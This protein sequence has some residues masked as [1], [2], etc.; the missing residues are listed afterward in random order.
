MS[1]QHMI[2]YLS[3][4]FRYDEELRDRVELVRDFDRLCD[5]CLKSFIRFVRTHTV[6]EDEI[7]VPETR[8]VAVRTRT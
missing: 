4:H 2:Q 7:L 8:R 3:K 5:A 1:R 6:E